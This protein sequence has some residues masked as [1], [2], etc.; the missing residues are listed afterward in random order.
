MKNKSLL[1][2]CFTLMVLIIANGCSAPPDAQDLAQTD[3]AQ[4]LHAQQMIDTIV[5]QTLLAIAT[6]QTAQPPTATAQMPSPTPTAT[7][8]AEIA[9]TGTPTPTAS[10]TVLAEVTVPTNCRTGPGKIFGRVSVLDVNVQ[11]EVIGRN[12]SGTYWII[13][14]PGGS[15]YCWLWDE[16]AILTGNTNALPI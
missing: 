3:I 1:I 11:A 16:Y 12:A 13:E 9:A 4:T 5:A 6:E 15:G 10:A 2:I 7:L 14:N 8:P